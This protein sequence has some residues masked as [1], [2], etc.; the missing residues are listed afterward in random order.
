MFA[1][2]GCAP[3]LMDSSLVGQMLR[4]A[5]PQCASSM[6]QT[7]CNMNSVHRFCGAVRSQDINASTPVLDSSRFTSCLLPRLRSI[8]PSPS[9]FQRVMVLKPLR[10]LIALPSVT[11]FLRVVATL[12]SYSIWRYGRI[13][14]PHPPLV[15][16]P[17]PAPSTQCNTFHTQSTPNRLLMYL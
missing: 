6:T 14:P 4:V 5:S 10:R 13:Q 17:A 11:L 3:C 7:Q 9:L 1:S 15:I 8:C 12:K 16:K 2:V